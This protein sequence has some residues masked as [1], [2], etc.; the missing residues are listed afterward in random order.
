MAKVGKIS[1]DFVKHLKPPAS[2]QH[3]EWDDKIPGFGVRI[4]AGGSV[5]FVLNYTL[6]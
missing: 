1:E 2:G 3:I 5:A 6:N 4:N